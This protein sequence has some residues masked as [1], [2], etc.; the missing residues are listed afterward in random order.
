MGWSFDFNRRGRRR[1]DGG[2]GHG[3][4]LRLGF[5]HHACTSKDENDSSDLRTPDRAPE[6]GSAA[7]GVTPELSD[8]ENDPGCPQ[9]E[10][11]EVAMLAPMRQ[12]EQ[13]ANCNCKEAE[14]GV[15]LDR[16]NGNA[17][18]GIAPSR[19]ERVGISDGPRDARA[20]AVA[21]AGE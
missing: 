7:K 20:R 14:C 10:A 18:R 17:E 3:N 4:A 1:L 9:K 6:Q 21:G 11:G 19:S 5:K 2:G 15:G 8:E 12:P 16:M 13:N